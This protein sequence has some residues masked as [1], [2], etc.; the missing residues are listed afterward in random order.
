MNDNFSQQTNDYYKNLNKHVNC[1]MCYIALTRDNYKKSRTVCEQCYNEHVLTYYKN[2][3]SSNSCDKIDISTQ[4]DFSSSNKTVRNTKKDSNNNK[5]KLYD[6]IIDTHPDILCDRLKDI[7][8][9]PM[10]DS[11]YTMVKTILD[12]LLRTKSIPKK[13]YNGILKQLDLL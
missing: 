6:H 1:S 8:S 10:L 4:T 12:E 7:L 3:F 2:K 9:K 13:H 11:D 5:T